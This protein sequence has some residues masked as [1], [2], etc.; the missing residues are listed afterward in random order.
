MRVAA[1]VVVVASFNSSNQLI[2][3]P[4]SYSTRTMSIGVS[5]LIHIHRITLTPAE[6]STIAS[7]GTVTLMTTAGGH[8]HT[9]IITKPG[10][11]CS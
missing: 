3:L 9:W 7:D 1:A 11:A 2:V 10:G 6:M 4:F 8:P 5:T